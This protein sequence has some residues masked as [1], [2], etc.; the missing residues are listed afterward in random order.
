[1]H[2]LALSRPTDRAGRVEQ[3]HEWTVRVEDTV[4]MFYHVQLSVDSGCHNVRVPARQAG[5]M[6]PGEKGN[7]HRH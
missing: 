1:M 3:G 2:E 4:E 5:E 7:G 6:D